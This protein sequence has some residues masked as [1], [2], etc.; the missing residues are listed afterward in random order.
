MEQYSLKEQYEKYTDN[1]RIYHASCP[2]SGPGYE[3]GNR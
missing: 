3:N 2:D 1:T